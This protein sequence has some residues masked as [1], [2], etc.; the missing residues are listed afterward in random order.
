[1]D[2]APTFFKYRYR[3]KCVEIGGGIVYGDL[4]HLE[5]KVYIA[6]NY[7]HKP[8]VEVDP[9][10]VVR[11]IGFNEAG[12]QIY[13]GDKVEDENGNIGIATL[14]PCVEVN[15]KNEPVVRLDWKFVSDK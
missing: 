5:G 6:E 2:F 1:M 7:G 3:G 14:K 15:P 12:W 11:L 4:L 10:S 8:S 13:E 9:Y